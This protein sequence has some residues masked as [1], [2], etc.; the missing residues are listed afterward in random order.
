MPDQNTKLSS[1]LRQLLDERDRAL[2]EMD[3]NYLRRMLP[4]ASNDEVRIMSAHKARYECT[5][6]PNEVRHA[7]RAWLAERGLKRV[8]L[9][10]LLPEGELP[11]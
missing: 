10:D 5:T 8:D 11:V 7:S 2:I 6:L 3:M 9:S 1:D 4:A